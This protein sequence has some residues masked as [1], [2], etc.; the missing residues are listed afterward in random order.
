MTPFYRGSIALLARLARKPLDARLVRVRRHRINERPVVWWVKR[1]LF[2]RLLVWLRNR[3][4]VWLR[5]RLRVARLVRRRRRQYGLSTHHRQR[6]PKQEVRR[7]KVRWRG[8]IQVPPLRL[9]QQ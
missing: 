3:L 4:I 9:G 6:P 5:N 7:G 1:R 2:Y 8:G